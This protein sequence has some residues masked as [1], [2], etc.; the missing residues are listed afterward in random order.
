M[1][2][3]MRDERRY[4]SDDRDLE[5]C[6]NDLAIFQ[7]ENG[8]WYVSILPHGDRVTRACVRITTSGAP[9]GLQ[10]VAAAVAN[11]YQTLAGDR[12]CFKP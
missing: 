7:G 2:P 8:D 9:R 12:E 10:G 11:L 3:A 1:L 5:D 6:D 4:R